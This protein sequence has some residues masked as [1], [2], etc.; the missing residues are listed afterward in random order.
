M[1]TL[2]SDEQVWLEQYRSVLDERYPDLVRDIIV[3]GSKARGDARNDSDLDILL[4]I[5]EGD[6]R[7][8]DQLAGIGDHL[9][10][11]SDCVPS[12]IVLTD[13]EKEKKMER[14]SSF[15]ETVDKEGISI[16]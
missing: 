4:V 2:N 16:R 13:E 3:F 9:A 7:L 8:K 12:I 11:G 14:Q 1:L 10:I 6:W 5:K 15:L